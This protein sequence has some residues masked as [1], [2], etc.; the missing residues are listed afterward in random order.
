MQSSRFLKT[1]KLGIVLQLTETPSPGV[2]GR[3][4]EVHDV[5]RNRGFHVTLMEAT[6]RETMPG[7]KP[8]GRNFNDDEIDGGL[9]LA[10]ERALVT[11]PEKVAGSL[12]EVSVTSQ[13]LYDFVGLKT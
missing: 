12:Y 1:P 10:I 4:W 6:L 11:P 7:R 5:E 2:R 13:D 3:S 9:G 8:I